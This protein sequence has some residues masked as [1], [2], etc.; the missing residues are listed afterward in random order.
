VVLA[1]NLILHGWQAAGAVFAM[2]VLF[3]WLPGLTMADI[4]IPSDK[5]FYIQS[6]GES[7]HGQD[8]RAFRVDL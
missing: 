7:S 1:A 5:L 3:R 2:S 6:A 8:W 4:I